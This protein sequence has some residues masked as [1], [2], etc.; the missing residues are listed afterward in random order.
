MFEA[1][2]LGTIKV[3]EAQKIGR[4]LPPNAPPVV[5]VLDTFSDRTKKF[6][7]GE[8][9]FVTLRK[10]ENTGLIRAKAKGTRKVQKSRH[11]IPS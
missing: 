3:W 11:K 8:V 9:T 5:S 2:I 6:D 1:N 7:E 10:R 4:A